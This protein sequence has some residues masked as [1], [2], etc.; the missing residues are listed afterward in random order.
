MMFQVKQSKWLQLTF[1]EKKN[2]QNEFLIAKD[3][4]IID[5][6]LH[7]GD[8][9]FL[10]IELKEEGIVIMNYKFILSGYV[11]KNYEKIIQLK[12]SFD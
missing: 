1:Q 8:K 10:T 5:H 6:K 9:V 4:I 3:E 7:E 11:E 12:T 2:E